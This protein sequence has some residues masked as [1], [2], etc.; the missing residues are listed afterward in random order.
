MSTAYEQTTAFGKGRLG[1]ERPHVG[2][3]RTGLNLNSLGQLQGVFY[4]DPEVANGAFD[5][6]VT[7]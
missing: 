2:L 6:G 4:V 3:D 1:R 7:E 5:L